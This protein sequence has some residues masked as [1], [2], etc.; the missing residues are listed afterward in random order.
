M[1]DKK[2]QEKLPDRNVFRY[3][4]DTDKE[5]NMNSNLFH[6]QRQP[7]IVSGKYVRKTDGGFLIK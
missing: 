6:G 2:V 7:F 4:T 3:L 5:W 1:G